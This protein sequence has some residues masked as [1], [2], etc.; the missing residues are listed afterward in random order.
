[1]QS[2]NSPFI[3]S[4]LHFFISSFLKSPFYL[5]YR[6]TSH[7]LLVTKQT[8]SLVLPTMPDQQSCP[9][10]QPS[11]APITSQKPGQLLCPAHSR[12]GPSG[13]LVQATAQSVRKQSRSTRTGSIQTQRCGLWGAKNP[14]LR[15]RRAPA[16]NIG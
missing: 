2:I 6:A 7:P 15:R 11:D 1:M 8:S 9:K 16:S 12:V 10:Q 13:L 14:C 3:S 4:F 5:Y